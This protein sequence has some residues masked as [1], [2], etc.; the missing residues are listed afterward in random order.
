[1]NYRRTEIRG[2]VHERAFCLIRSIQTYFGPHFYFLSNGY[3][4]LR[5]WLTFCVAEF[6]AMDQAFSL[7]HVTAFDALIL[8][9]VFVVYKVALIWAK[10]RR[11][12]K[13]AEKTP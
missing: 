12:I 8:H 10:E 11:D 13:K 4:G 1:M 3:L 9:G 2:P 5:S 6:L 7:R